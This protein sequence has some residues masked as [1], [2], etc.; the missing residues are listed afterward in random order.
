[1][2][3]RINKKL[4]NAINEIGTIVPDCESAHIREA[5]RTVKNVQESLGEIIQERQLAGGYKQ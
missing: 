5:K 3:D 1:M 4:E 2:E